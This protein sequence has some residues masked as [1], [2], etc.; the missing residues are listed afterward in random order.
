MKFIH[1]SAVL[2]AFSPVASGEQQQAVFQ[3][4]VTKADKPLNVAI[5]GKRS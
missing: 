5:I 2:H 4:P 3:A 1:L